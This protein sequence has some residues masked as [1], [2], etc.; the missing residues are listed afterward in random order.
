MSEGTTELSI[1][2]VAQQVTYF[3][4]AFTDGQQLKLIPVTAHG[5]R[6]VTWIAPMSMTITSIV[7]HLGGPYSDS[8]QTTTAIPFDRPGQFPVVGQWLKPGQSTLPRAAGVVGTGTTGGHAWRAT[9]YVGPWGTCVTVNEEGNDCMD[10]RP[11]GT[12]QVAGPMSGPVPGLQL[13]VVTAP[14]SV[15]KVTVTLSAGKPVTVKP[16]TFGGERLAAFAVGKAV[17]PTRWT[18]YNASGKQ[19]GTGAR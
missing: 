19:T 15:A 2:Q 9:A 6:Y 17:V 1:A 18:W 13:V 12:V 8:G 5:Y 4:V 10:S 14:E 7:A 11:G 3:I 16:A